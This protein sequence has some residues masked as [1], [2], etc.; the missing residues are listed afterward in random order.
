MME[1]A[2]ET[3]RNVVEAMKTLNLRGSILR[4]SPPAMAYDIKVDGGGETTYIDFL[5]EMRMRG[6]RLNN[7]VNISHECFWT[8]VVKCQ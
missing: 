5:I 1:E 8:V 4:L 3:F 7:T 6:Y 2:T